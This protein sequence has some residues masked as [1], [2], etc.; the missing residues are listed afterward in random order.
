M[1]DTL[2]QVLVTSEDE[3]VDV[4][5]PLTRV[6]RGLLGGHHVEARGSLDGV[7]VGI[8]I[9]FGSKWAPQATPDP[10]HPFQL[11][12]ASLVSLGAESDELVAALDRLYGTGIDARTMPRPVVVDAMALQGDP[13]LLHKQPVRF[14]LF[15]N[16]QSED[17]AAYAELFV[18][19]LPQ[20]SRLLLNEKALEYR[21][22]VVGT[23]AGSA[24]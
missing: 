21:A 17:E 23:L 24:G 7:S 6:R 13:K 12:Q 15:F 16:S 4:D 9:D 20:E 8:A 2:A 10:S 3:F 1:G 5:L 22:G 18:V 11:G 14:K 19:V